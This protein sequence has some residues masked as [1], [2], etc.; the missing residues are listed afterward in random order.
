MFSTNLP[1]G[2]TKLTKQDPAKTNSCQLLTQK[3]LLQ[4]SQS[5]RRLVWRGLRFGKQPEAGKGPERRDN[6]KKK[7]EATNK[8]IANNH[9]VVEDDDDDAGLGD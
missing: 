9:L 3:L 5:G 7:T 6:N 1:N 4:T 8:Q 2:T